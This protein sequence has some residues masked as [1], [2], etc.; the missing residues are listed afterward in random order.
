MILLHSF[1]EFVDKSDRKSGNSIQIPC[2][3]VIEE[4]FMCLLVGMV[5]DPCKISFTFGS[6]GYFYSLAVLIF[7]FPEPVSIRVISFII[8]KLSNLS[9]LNYKLIINPILV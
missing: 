8:S 2:M 9:S 7:L 3:G 1:H 5:S 4:M 6:L